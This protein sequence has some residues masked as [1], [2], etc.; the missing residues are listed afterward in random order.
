MEWGHRGSAPRGALGLVTPGHITL[1]A[2]RHLVTTA[3]VISDHLT[4][5]RVADLEA[6]LAP[7]VDPGRGVTLG[8]AGQHHILALPHCL[9]VAGPHPGG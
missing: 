4:R 1:A 8:L 9:V 7:P 5:V 3:L 6:V 2:S